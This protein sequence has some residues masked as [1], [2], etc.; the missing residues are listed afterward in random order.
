MPRIDRTIVRSVFMGVAWLLAAALPTL[1]EDL[2]FT[3]YYPAPSSS[4][5]TE[6]RTNQASV[7]S[8][9]N[10]VP[11]ADGQLVIQGW[12]DVGLSTGQMRFRTQPSGTP[13]TFLIA[14]PMTPNWVGG[15]GIYPKGTPTVSAYGVQNIA[16]S[17]ELMGTDYAANP[18]SYHDFVMFEGSNRI[19]FVSRGSGTSSPGVYEVPPD[20]VFTSDSNASPNH[21]LMTITAAGSVG[22]GTTAPAYPL[23]VYQNNPN[24][25]AGVLK[26]EGNATGQSS[27]LLTNSSPGGKEWRFDSMGSGSGWTGGLAM[28][29]A[30]FVS[31]PPLFISGSTGNVGI[32]T[33]G[34]GEKLEVGGNIKNSGTLSVGTTAQTGSANRFR[35][36]QS[37]VR[38]RFLGNETIRSSVFSPLNFNVEDFDTDALHSPSTPSR[39]TAAIAGKYLSSANLQWSGSSTAGQ[40]QMRI[41]LNGATDIAGNTETPTAAAAGPFMGISTVYA[42]AAGD[43]VQL[44]VWQSS[45]GNLDLVAGGMTHFEMVYLGE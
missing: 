2:T 29:T 1:A 9:V 35:M 45:G 20:F 26:V 21:D 4:G 30:A 11:L 7:G 12:F 24:N 44:I 36:L 34:P 28:R 15:I 33:A 22:I 5:G 16:S 3:T 42:L 17:F 27:I 41:Q 19:G 25:G 39:L 13:Y 32:W 14:Q 18:N 10:T 23:H 38:V 6:L 31:P 8:S 43:Y 40:R 37:M